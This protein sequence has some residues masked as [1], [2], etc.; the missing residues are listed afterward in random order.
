MRTF[1]S[2]TPVES[3]TRERVAAEPVEAPIVGERWGR[4]SQFTFD[5]QG[6]E[7][8]PADDGG[9]AV[10]RWPA[11]RKRSVRV[12]NLTPVWRKYDVVRIESAD[13][14]AVFVEARITREILIPISSTQ[15]KFVS[16]ALGY[17]EDTTGYAYEQRIIHT[18]LLLRIPSPAP[19]LE[20]VDRGEEGDWP[21]Y[22][23][24]LASPGR[25]G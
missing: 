22:P 9:G 14:P 6:P 7:S 10:V 23:E 3:H 4:P 21:P 12:Y 2:F 8:D 24:E 19:G 1:W 5:E 11:D 20:V 18:Y 25:I 16:M 13:D 15:Q 17:L